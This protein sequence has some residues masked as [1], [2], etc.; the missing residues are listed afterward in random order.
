[1]KLRNLVVTTLLAIVL[2]PC[3]ANAENVIDY[4]YN[5]QQY[6][7]GASRYDFNY[8]ND[9][10]EV[11]C[12]NIDTTGDGHISVKSGSYSNLFALSGA[13]LINVDDSNNSKLELEYKYGTGRISITMEY[14]YTIV[15]Y[16][17]NDGS[18]TIWKEHK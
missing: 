17:K 13:N 3:I 7:W 11:V 15:S 16:F 18:F 12:I 4:C 2:C 8:K 5:V 14:G 9:T 10:G 1:M 6:R